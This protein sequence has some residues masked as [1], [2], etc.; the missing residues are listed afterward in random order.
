MTATILRR[1]DM[2]ET[3]RKTFHEAVTQ[4]HGRIWADLTFGKVIETHTS[5]KVYLPISRSARDASLQTCT[6]AKCFTD[7]TSSEVEVNTYR[8]K[9][10]ATFYL[11]DDCQREA[12]VSGPDTKPAPRKTRLNPGFEED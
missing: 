9:G 3:T 6:C 4:T 8:Y 12:F 7:L 5:R 2:S 1:L 10:Q 11:C